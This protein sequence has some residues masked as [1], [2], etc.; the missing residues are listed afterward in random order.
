MVE[1]CEYCH[2]RFY[3]PANR[4][5]QGAQGGTCMIVGDDEQLA[6][7]IGAAAERAIGCQVRFWACV[8][9]VC[10]HLGSDI[11]TPASK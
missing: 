5:L 2:L 3:V 11:S 10:F 9:P 4:M 6:S 8:S 7:E 1:D